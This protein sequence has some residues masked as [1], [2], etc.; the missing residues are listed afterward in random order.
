MW[1]PFYFIFHQAI[2]RHSSAPLAYFF[3]WLNVSSHG[4]VKLKTVEK[5]KVFFLGVTPFPLVLAEVFQA[6]TEG[7]LFP[8]DVFAHAYLPF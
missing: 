5:K 8:L 3:C 4:R 2:C 7:V 6:S 1:L